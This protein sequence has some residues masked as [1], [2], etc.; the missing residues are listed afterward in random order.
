MLAEDQAMMR[1]A[2]AVLLELETDLTVVAQVGTGTDVVS[3]AILACPDVALL[4]IEMPGISGIDACRAL[5]R[6]LPS[7]QVIMVTTFGR[8]GYLRRALEAGA[9]GFVVKDGP[10]EGLAR[11]IRAVHGGETVVDPN[12]AA[13]AIRA[14]DSPLTERE[15]DVLNAARDGSTATDIAT[16]LHLSDSTVRNYLSSAI[17]KTGTRNRIEAVNAARD[18]GWL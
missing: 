14:G 9:H 15:R 10:V 7:C 5:R 13:G 12:L 17:G 11:A 3:E 2:L 4:D 1:D 18:N 6:E 8:P 16:Q